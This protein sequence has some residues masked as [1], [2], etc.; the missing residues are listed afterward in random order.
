MPSRESAKADFGPWLPLIHPPVP[1]TAAMPAADDFLTLAAPGEAQTRVKASVFLAHAAPVAS[2]EEARAL[3]ASRGK[4][5]WDANHHC[6]AWR[7]RG[8]VARANDAG[9][10]G[11][12][13]GA[14]IHAA[15]EGAGRV[16][17]GVIVTRWFGGTRLGVGGLVRAYGEAAALALEAAPR[18]VG[19]IAARLRVR[20]PYPHTAAV[21]R[22]L[23]RAGAAAIEHGYEAA[24]HG[25]VVDCSVPA[26]AE[27][28]VGDELREA[29]SGAVA[30]EHLGETVLYRN[31]AG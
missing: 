12:R 29:T 26:S 7:L 1:S 15:I 25:G 4:A 8:G 30:P 2:E 5:M 28:R 16:D 27:A 23:E 9:E 13:A 3:L 6:S 14:P 19:T 18:R 10:P 17:V 20:Y 11:G 24:G 22:V 31:A 21:M